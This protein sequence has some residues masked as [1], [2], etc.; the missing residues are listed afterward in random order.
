MGLTVAAPVSAC[1]LPAVR[2]LLVNTNRETTP[3]PVLPIGVLRCAEA[4]EAAGIDV[5]VVDLAFARNPVKALGRA[6]RKS[7]P[8]MIGLGVRNID[9]CDARSPRF[10]TGDVRPLVAAIRGLTDAKVVAGGAGPSLAPEQARELLGVDCVV[11]GPGEDILPELWEADELPGVVRGEQRSFDAPAPDYARWLDL[12]PY[13]RRGTP[14]GVQSRTGC[15]FRCVY[16]NYSGIEGGRYEL[17]DPEA[18]VGAI[19][20]QVR[21]TGLKAVEFVDSTF[22]SPPRF[23]HDL[24]DR[25]AARG[26]GLSLGASGITPHHSNREL[27][28]AMR[29]AGFSSMWVSPDS[30]CPTTIE[31]YGKGF[32]VDELARMT[33]ETREGGI[34]VLWSFMFGGPD[35][36]EETVGETLRFIQEQIHPEDPVL[37]TAR[38]R[39]YPGTALATRAAE[40]GYPETVLDPFEPGQYYLSPQIEAGVLDGMLDEA[41]KRL[42]NVMYMDESQGGAVPWAQ[43]AYA[44]LGRHFPVWADV[45]KLRKILRK[46]RV[47]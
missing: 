11:A 43:R 22:N 6:I 42:T 19:E 16:C 38:M 34:L 28:K 21:R 30:A 26:L 2:L 7:E 35:E 17:G 3:S 32:T 36:T 12:G 46:L 23:A 40:E 13:R 1:T 47:A 5:D 33:R 25:I 44:L 37:F 31:S 20:E 29:A 45:P 41:K 14:I 18:V 39:I 24:C 27:L 9:N 10:Y 4:C 15:P 8:R